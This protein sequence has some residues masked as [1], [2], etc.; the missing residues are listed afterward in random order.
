MGWIKHR[1]RLEAGG[2]P[3]STGAPFSSWL[4]RAPLTAASAVSDLDYSDI[5]VSDESPCFCQQMQL[6]RV[7][8]Q[9]AVWRSSKAIRSDYSCPNSEGR[10]LLLSKNLRVLLESQI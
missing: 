7:R 4:S 5:S 10:N 3:G 6:F 2:V 1:G 9:R 8:S